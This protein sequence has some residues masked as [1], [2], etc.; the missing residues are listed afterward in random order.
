[1]ISYG[2]NPST[3]RGLVAA[4]LESSITDNPA[5][6]RQASII[7]LAIRPQSAGS[8]RDLEFRKGTLVVSCMAGIPAG[9][10]NRTLGIP[11]IRMMPSGPETL[12][13]HNGI[14]A[15]YPHNQLLEDIL[16]LLGQDVHVMPDEDLLNVFTA[17]V[18]LPAAIRAAR[19]M[20]MDTG[21]GIWLVTQEFPIVSPIYSWA[22]A[23]I[24]GEVSAAEREE[25]I[26]N[27]ST[28]AG[29]TEAFVTSIRSGADF[30]TAFHAAIARSRT[31]SREM[32][33]RLR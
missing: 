12:R 27:M 8:I 19:G 17:G 7:F 16:S 4:G 23:T 1:M 11:V 29:I 32:E 10:L 13:S 6:C 25:Y 20:G 26:R 21:R 31:I 2:S 30:S 33:Q 24:P 14:V 18:C 15:I 5:M 22:V 9:L 3:R 28:K